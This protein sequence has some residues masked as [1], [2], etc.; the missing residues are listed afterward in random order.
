[1]SSTESRIAY[2]IM[3]KKEG[4]EGISDEWTEEDDWSIFR[5]DVIW[6]NKKVRNRGRKNIGCEKKMIKVG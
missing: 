5:L 2:L 1:M 6:G 4:I 3:A